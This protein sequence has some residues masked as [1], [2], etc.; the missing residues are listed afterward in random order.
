MSKPSKN[1][2]SK[3]SFK[4]VC[5]VPKTEAVSITDENNNKKTVLRG[6]EQVYMRVIGV[7]YSTKVVTS[8]YGDS[9]EFSGQFQG[10]NL[11]TGEVYEGGKLFLPNVA[12]M[13]TVGA[14]NVASHTDG[15][16]SLDVAFDIGVKPAN[17]AHGYEYTIKPLIQAEPTESPFARFAAILPP[18]P[19]SAPKLEHKK[20]KK[21]TETATEE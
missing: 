19:S 10:I 20:N 11:E 16:K 9:I 8:T 3:V 15:F 18:L 17:T 7:I 1:L 21:S 12:E 4:T 5:G 13:Y 14:F 2:V 6:I